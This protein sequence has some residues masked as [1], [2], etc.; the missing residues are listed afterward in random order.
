[1]LVAIASGEKHLSAKEVVMKYELG[2]AQTIA[3]NKKALVAKD[4]VELRNGDFTFVDPVFLL[5]FKQL[6]NIA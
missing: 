2:G 6:Y 5:W 3:K 4:I 1:M